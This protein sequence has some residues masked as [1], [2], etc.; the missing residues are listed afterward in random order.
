MEQ[1]PRYFGKTCVNTYS[2]H[3][4][5]NVQTKFLTEIPM[6]IELPF[7]D[8]IFEPSCKDIIE[9]LS[10]IIHY[11][12]G[13]KTSRYPNNK[14]CIMWDLWQTVPDSIDVI[15]GNV[16]LEQKVISSGC[17]KLAPFVVPK[18]T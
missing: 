5:F 14:I 1:A 4:S 13:N 8:L 7:M 9:E 2:W 16:T 6:W 15:V 17:L 3:M 11:I 12:H 18:I 10:R